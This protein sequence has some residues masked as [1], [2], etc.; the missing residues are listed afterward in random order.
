MR[1][2]VWIVN[3]T[4]P[5]KS[6]SYM[7]DLLHELLAETHW[8]TIGKKQEYHIWIIV[9]FSYMG[10]SA[11]WR[12]CKIE[13]AISKAS[14]NKRRCSAGS[15][16]ILSFSFRRPT[17]IS[18]LVMWRQENTNSLFYLN[19]TSFMFQKRLV[20]I[21]FPWKECYWTKVSVIWEGWLYKIAG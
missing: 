15:I 17:F 21:F 6:L 1:Y 3:D 10:P 20:I 7:L 16:S 4:M 8:R 19:V 13:H 5:T 18:F 11:K 14:W 12:R 2:E 9:S